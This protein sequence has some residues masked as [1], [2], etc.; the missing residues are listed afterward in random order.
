[1]VL[2][3]AVRRACLQAA[4]RAGTGAGL[5]V[6]AGCRDTMGG[7]C[8]ARTVHAADPRRPRPARGALGRPPVT[9]FQFVALLL[10]SIGP[11]LALGRLAPVPDTLVLFGAGVAATLVPGLP[12]PHLDP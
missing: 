1:M 10:A 4:D 6:S 7:G 11:I 9:S 2:L 12:P 8:D 3:D 5:G